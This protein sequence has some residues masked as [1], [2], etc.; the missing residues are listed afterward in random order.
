LNLPLASALFL[1]CVSSAL[2]GQLSNSVSSRFTG[3]IN[4]AAPTN[5]WPEALWS[6]KVVPQEFSGAV[7]SNLMA[8]GSFTAKD[9]IPTPAHLLAVDP[10]A[11]YLGVMGIKYLEILPT[12]GY[13]RYHDDHAR[14]HWTSSVKG[15]SEPV[16]RVP[17]QDQITK[18]GL[19]YA[20]LAGVE[21]SQ[22]ATKPGTLDPMIECVVQS[23]QR[24]GPEVPNDPLET[25]IF[26]IYFTRCIDGIP[27]TK[28]GDFEVSFGNNEKVFDLEVSWRNLQPYQLLSNITTPAQVI[29][30]IRN[31]QTH[32]PQ[33]YGWPLD[34]IKILT[35]TNAT[36]RYS[37]GRPREPMD[38]VVPALQLDAI[39][40][41]G[42]TNRYIWFQSSILA[43]D[44]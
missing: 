40:D 16:I 8:L 38:F 17:T 1:G 33:L 26:G 31:G 6:Y 27:V 15:V 13:L 44:K 21:V 20:R 2:A 25:N 9:Q 37:R 19:K 12:L 7:I 42:K 43:P 30:W 14:A 35:I 32:L 3:E 4:W 34:Q 22:L 41:N 29:G 24:V 23:R 39:I 10:K 5:I 28:F 36:P 11:R 18:L